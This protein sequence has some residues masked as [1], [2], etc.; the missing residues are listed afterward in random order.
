MISGPHTQTWCCPR[1]H[2]RVPEKPRRLRPAAHLLAAVHDERPATTSSGSPQTRH[3]ALQAQAP[4]G[5]T[6]RQRVGPASSCCCPS[7]DR[8]SARSPARRVPSSGPS[9]PR[10]ADWWH[11]V[12]K[13]KRSTEFAA[14]TASAPTACLRWNHVASHHRPEAHASIARP[15]KAR[16]PVNPV[17]VSAATAEGDAVASLASRRAA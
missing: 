11:V 14:C 2:R 17:K 4:N 8:A 12:K 7:R 3:R 16:K 1:T 9:V 10:K 15:P 5:I 6:S 13:A